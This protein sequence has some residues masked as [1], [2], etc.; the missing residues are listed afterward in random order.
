[1]DPAVLQLVMSLLIEITKAA[2][3]LMP[4]ISQ[5]IEKITDIEELKKLPL[6]DF[7]LV[8]VD[9]LQETIND[10]K[11]KY[12]EREAELLGDDNG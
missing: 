2:V 3:K 12:A 10:I 6:D 1:M 8:P 7:K 9:E 11:K 4:L 5:E